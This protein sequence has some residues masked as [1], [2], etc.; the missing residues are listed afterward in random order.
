MK[1]ITINRYEFAT[2]SSKTDNSHAYRLN[3]QNY[4]PRLARTENKI[5]KKGTSGPVEFWVLYYI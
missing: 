5:D 3:E 4:K 2:F 1:L